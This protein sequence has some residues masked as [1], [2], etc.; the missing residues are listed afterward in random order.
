MERSRMGWGGRI[1]AKTSFLAE[2]RQI[3]PGLAGGTGTE[4]LILLGLG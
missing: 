4:T 3:S 2:T 1:S